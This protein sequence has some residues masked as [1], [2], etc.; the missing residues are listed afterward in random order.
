MMITLPGEVLGALCRHMGTSV[1]ESI[2]AQ[3]LEGIQSNLERQPLDQAGQ[4]E[5]KQA[6]I[7]MEKLVGTEATQKVIHSGYNH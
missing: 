2:K 3:L 7:L 1:Y 6:D 4:S 5:Q